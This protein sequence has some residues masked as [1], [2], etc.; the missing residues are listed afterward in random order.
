MQKSKPYTNCEKECHAQYMLAD[1]K[2]QYM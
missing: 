1:F 2:V